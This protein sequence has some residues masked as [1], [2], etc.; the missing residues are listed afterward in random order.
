MR[1][2]L[3]AVLG[4]TLVGP[5]GA[6]AQ[7]R[8]GF[9]GGLAGSTLGG[10][11]VVGWKTRSGPLGG[12]F[13]TLPLSRVV[14]LRP[15]IA[16]TSKGAQDE[17]DVFRVA[18][19]IQYFQVSFLGQFSL[20]TAAVAQPYAVIGP[21]VGLKFRCDFGVTDQLGRHSS[22]DCDSPLFQG[23]FPVRANDMGLLM[24]AGVT[25]GPSRRLSGL[26]ELTYEL[27]LM[28]IDAGTPTY[29]VKNRSFAVKAGVLFALG[30]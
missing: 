10:S 5:A 11:D 21:V 26:L 2:T 17:V 9:Y 27:G 25:L 1:A 19:T 30:G 13:V 18:L 23:A 8:V 22:A 16:W 3:L 24:G 28:S 12:G 6:A 14:A 4:F 20:P 7:P 29:D 15:G